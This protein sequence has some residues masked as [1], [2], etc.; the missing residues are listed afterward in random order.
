MAYANLIV[1][2]FV[3][4]RRVVR[5]DEC[6]A[7]DNEVREGDEKCDESLVRGRAGSQRRWCAQDGLAQCV[8]MLEHDRADQFV[9]VPEPVEHR[10]LSDAGG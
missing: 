7:I 3:L 10:R 8:R 9:P 6:G 1:G 2:A 4:A 5:G